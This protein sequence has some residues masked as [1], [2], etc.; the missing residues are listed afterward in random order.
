M[1]HHSGLSTQFIRSVVISPDEV[2]KELQLQIP[3]WRR[4]LDAVIPEGLRPWRNP[5][6]VSG[7]AGRLSHVNELTVTWPHFDSED[8]RPPFM[9][10]LWQTLAPSLRKLT[11]S[12]Q[13][14][15]LINSIAPTVQLPQLE[16]FYIMLMAGFDEEIPP[17]QYDQVKAT[18]SSF[19]NHFRSTLQK[20]S[21]TSYMTHGHLIPLLE[22]F[23]QL[24]H[25][26]HLELKIP[27]DTTQLSG[28]PLV[29]FLANHS[30]QIQSLALK[31]DFGRR[32]LEDAP[33][34][35][36]VPWKSFSQLRTLSLPV[37]TLPLSE[38]SCG[39]M[40]RTCFLDA[41]PLLKSLSISG[42]FSRAESGIIGL[43]NDQVKLLVGE[44]APLPESQAPLEELS[45]VGR[46]LVPELFFILFGRLPH[47]K[48]LS[49]H[50]EGVIDAENK[51]C[52][53]EPLREVSAVIAR[54]DMTL[55]ESCLFPNLNSESANLSTF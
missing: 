6:I 8:A 15:R 34:L 53:P 30:R 37:N 25:L 54:K 38:L 27:F 41:F 7:I 28:M 39:S 2:H 29:T 48:K 45:L 1:Q 13:M 32:P 22:G 36:T 50:F 40:A 17:E 18:L 26:R 46:I 55:R 49:L 35:S 16:E 19:A 12:T 42:S 31:E 5:D 24:D 10:P 3:I 51:K 4:P 23:G 47:L 20:L 33:F 43:D 44:G 14:L 11:I 9:S 21:V 52:A